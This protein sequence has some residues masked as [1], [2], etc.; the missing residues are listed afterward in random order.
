MISNSKFTAG[1]MEITCD[2]SEL[3]AKTASSE[4]YHVE[5][6]GSFEQPVFRV[7]KVSNEIVQL[8]SMVTEQEKECHAYIAGLVSDS[9]KHELVL[10]EFA[11]KRDIGQKST[12]GI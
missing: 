11:G 2:V 3:I 1:S 6:V 8:G 10:S 7:L 4:I 5:L 9:F 12:S